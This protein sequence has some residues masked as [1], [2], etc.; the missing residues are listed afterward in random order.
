MSEPDDGWTSIIVYGQDHILPLTLRYFSA[1]PARTSS[2]RLLEACRHKS[3]DTSDDKLQSAK[4]RVTSVVY[5]K[6]RKEY[7]RLNDF[8]KMASP[9]LPVSEVQE[10]LSVPLCCQN[11][12]G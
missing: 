5:H 10:Q 6:M 9:S 11:E 12:E 7:D 3:N 2:Y 8:T 4:K 1:S